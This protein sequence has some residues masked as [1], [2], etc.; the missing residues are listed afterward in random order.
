MCS[1]WKENPIENIVQQRNCIL[2][3][4]LGAHAGHT[5]VDL[6]PTIPSAS[7][8]EDL[9][10]HRDQDER[11]ISWADVLQRGLRQIPITAAIKTIS[12][13]GWGIHSGPSLAPDTSSSWCKHLGHVVVVWL[14]T[15]AVKQCSPLLSRTPNKK[16][17]SSGLDRSPRIN[18][19]YGTC[20]KR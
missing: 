9:R 8:S 18:L 16:V 6:C 7:S 10:A 5:R 1:L 2:P 14:V 12:G 15:S 13:S 19:Y 3:S 17:H 11:L 4:Q 20:S